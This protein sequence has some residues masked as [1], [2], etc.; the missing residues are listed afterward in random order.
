MDDQYLKRKVLRL[1]NSR[2]K[3]NKCF[4][5]LYSNAVH[6]ND[7]L[8]ILCSYNMDL[9]YEQIEL[10]SNNIDLIPR[11]TM[12]AIYWRLNSKQSFIDTFVQQPYKYFIA[13]YAGTD[14]IRTAVSAE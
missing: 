11:E 14:H 9:T 4:K 6:F 13:K 1:Q 7:G 12:C 3:K 2:Q 10:L 5:C 8:C